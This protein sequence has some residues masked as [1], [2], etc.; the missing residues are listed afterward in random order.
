M[1][2]IHIDRVMPITA[3]KTMNIKHI[4]IM[5]VLLAALLVWVAPVPVA[6]QDAAHRDVIT[7]VEQAL[8]FMRSANYSEQE[9]ATRMNWGYP[10]LVNEMVSYNPADDDRANYYSLLMLAINHYSD[11]S[12]RLNIL[13]RAI[14]TLD[15]LVQ[16]FFPQWIIQDEPLILEIMR[17]IRDN[18]DDI[19]DMEAVEVA[20]RLMSGKA[21]MRVVQRP[22]DENNLIGIII[23]KARP[24]SENNPSSAGF[25]INR[26]D[27]DYEDY[28]LVGRRILRETLTADVY[29]KLVAR[30]YPH[31]MET[32]V[33]KPAPYV[34]E[35]GISIPFGGG[36]MWTLS[37]DERA[38]DGVSLKVSR[39]RAGFELKI[40]QD[41]VNLPFLY[42]PQWN[43]LIVYEPDPTEYVKA[44]IAVP[45]IWG[46]QNIEKDFGLFKHRKLNGTLGFSGE[47][48][49]QLS[50]SSAGRESDAQ[51][52]GAATFIS[53][54]IKSFGNKTVTDVNGIII[55]GDGANPDIFNPTRYNTFYHITATATGYYW[56]DL[57]SWLLEGLRLHIGAGYMKVEGSK[58][59]VFGPPD[60][61]ASSDISITD[62]LK[63]VSS[64]A[65]MDAFVK[66]EYNSTGK[67]IYGVSLQY[68]NG[69]IMGELYLNIF[70]WLRAQVK[71]S[72]LVFRDPEIWE[73]DEMIVPGLQFRFQF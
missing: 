26:D 63:T 59:K 4:I 8:R 15:P 72:R 32:G 21:K 31:T 61:V 27:P 66:L 56:R 67:T 42:G 53:F 33:I 37:T 58:R 46:D 1:N 39:V 64:K 41:W 25:M 17:K 24:V 6:A 52:I 16:K 50:S 62:S 2:R 71:Y 47:Y 36:F 18:R 73:Y 54:G 34:A 22:N 5:S 70:E 30:D 23:E 12:M 51:G 19:S 57:G 7:S 10:K 65:V 9:L 38:K 55:N 44:G 69:S 43:L 60:A 68:F 45:F 49:K 13:I 11:E 40:G 14:T 35:S 3:R 48:W 28:R 20:E 29:E